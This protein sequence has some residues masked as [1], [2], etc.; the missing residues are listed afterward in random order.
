[1]KKGV[2]ILKEIYFC[3]DEET[4]K[5]MNMQYSSIWSF[6][7]ILIDYDNQEIRTFKRSNW[8]SS[9]NITEVTKF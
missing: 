9:Y 2:E 7:Q 5:V 3:S 4:A 6:I 8:N 1:M